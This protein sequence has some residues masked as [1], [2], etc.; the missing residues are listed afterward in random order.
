MKTP[1]DFE[2]WQEEVSL[3]DWV[4]AWVDYAHMIDHINHT[5]EKKHCPDAIVVSIADQMN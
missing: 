4:N 5:E 2:R 3:I 1:R